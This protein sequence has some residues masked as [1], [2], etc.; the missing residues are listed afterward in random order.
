[1]KNR[2]CIRSSSFQSIRMLAALT[3]FPLLRDLTADLASRIGRSMN[4]DV[5]AAGQQVRGLRVVQARRSLHRARR[6]VGDWHR[7][8]GIRPGLRRPMEM[9]GGAGA[10]E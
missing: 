8:P 9:S 6:G 2:N 10:R 5:V 1:M 4:V 7:N 3:T